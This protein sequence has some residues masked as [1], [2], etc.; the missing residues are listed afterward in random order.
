M[1]KYKIVVLFVL[2]AAIFILKAGD[3]KKK[4]KYG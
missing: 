4:P 3:K 2:M 1:F